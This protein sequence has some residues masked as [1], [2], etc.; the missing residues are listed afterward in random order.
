MKK[1]E[2]DQDQR[3]IIR[4]V[5]ENPGCCKE[6][7]VSLLGDYIGRN[8]VLDNLTLLIDEGMIIAKKGKQI[9][10]LYINKGDP[11]ASLSSNIQCFDNAFSGLLSDVKKELRE[12]G[13]RRSN[14]LS[15]DQRH[16]IY[17][18]ENKL[19][20]AI[21]DIY[22]WFIY[23]HDIFR[24]TNFLNNSDNETLERI[25][26]TVSAVIREIQA[27]L[28]DTLSDASFVPDTI[29][30]DLTHLD[31]RNP[32]EEDIGTFYLLKRVFDTNGMAGHFER[33]M[34]IMWKVISDVHNFKHSRPFEFNPVV[35]N[36][37]NKDWK[38]VLCVYEEV[39]E[40]PLVVNVKYQ[41]R[42]LMYNLPLLEGAN[43]VRRGVHIARK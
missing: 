14:S 33:V 41:Q 32:F 20:H 26:L 39:F 4:C 9:Y 30:V 2:V 29:R 43:Y 34:D 5:E 11:I 22:R 13:K 17:L 42:K 36:L 10:Q 23:H 25:Y 27:K 40:N 21:F 19:L 38:K 37:D 1:L 16:E 15:E 35:S 6:N 7:V 8:N 12:L 18:V 24:N 3:R 28:L 31:L